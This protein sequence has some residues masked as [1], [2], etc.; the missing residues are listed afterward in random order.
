[1][2]INPPGGI[3]NLNDL[4]DITKLAGPSSVAGLTGGLSGIATKFSDLG[5]SFPSPS[6]AAGMLNNIEIPSIP[7]LNSAASDLSSF[8]A[9]LAPDIKNLTGSGFGVS[10]LNGADG[11]PSITDFTHAVSGGPE[12]AA[13]AASGNNITPAQITALENSL[14]KTQVLLGN[15]GIDL[16]SLPGTNLST[17]LTFATGLHKYGAASIGSAGSGG[18]AD[19]LKTM[20]N[21]DSHYGDAIVASLAEGKNKSLMMAN[22]IKPPNFG[23]TPFK[24]LPSAGSINSLGSASALLGGS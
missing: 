2:G 5:A 23:E 6:A 19:I 12:L 1:L 15:V 11:L 16:S 22:G 10:S 20:A 21:T 3:Q 18:V 24:N 9:G 7:K 4:T 17:S 13:L 14:T 8:T